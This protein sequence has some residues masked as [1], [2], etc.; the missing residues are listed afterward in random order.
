MFSKRKMVPVKT[1]EQSALSL[2]AWAAFLIV[3]SSALSCMFSVELVF[4]RMTIPVFEWAVIACYIAAWKWLTRERLSACA[5]K[6]VLL[7]FVL[8]ISFLG[9]DL[10]SQLWSDTPLRGAYLLYVSGFI[11]MVS[12]ILAWWGGRLMAHLIDTGGDPEDIRKDDLIFLPIFFMALYH[13]VFYCTSGHRSRCVMIC[14]MIAASFYL[15]RQK[16][17]IETIRRSLKPLSRVVTDRRFLMALVFCV[18]F[19]ARY[20]FLANLLRIEGAD[21]PLASDDGPTYDRWARIGAKDPMVFLRESPFYFKVFYS[22]LPALVYRV[23]GHSYCVLGVIQSLLGAL[24]A[25]GI[26]V[27]TSMILG[28]RSAA[29]IASCGIAMNSTLIHL[30]TTITTE[31]LYIPL[32]VFFITL[33]LYYRESAHDRKA[34][35]LLSLAGL[36]CGIAAVVRE[37]ALGIG[38]F[39]ALWILIWGRPYLRSGFMRRTRDAIILL[40]FMAIP[41]L[42][43]TSI[44]YRNTGEFYLV[45]KGQEIRDQSGEIVGWRKAGSYEWI[46]KSSVWG[47]D[48]VPSNQRLVELGIRDPFKDPLGSLAAAARSPQAVLRALASIV[49]KRMRNLFFWPNF[50]RFDPILLL[51]GSQYATRYASNL[52][53]Y[54]VILIVFSVFAFLFS[55]IPWAHKSLLLIV[56]VFYTLFHGILFLSMNARYRSPMDPFLSVITAFGIST[57]VHYYRRTAS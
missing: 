51:N 13:A 29:F 44:N 3:M 46:V 47:E 16:A 21:Y 9:I 55:G 41:V 40:F 56:I 15:A 31:A 5:I 4:R 28:K 24:V 19:L 11:V 10:E 57:L 20:L 54:I 23:F 14:A 52:E 42:F 34:K 7:G 8:S 30:S 1:I 45:Y 26:F 27:L 6:G 36:L 48:L 25:L 53:F 18:A 35:A 49:P 32:I 43:I 39:V 33:V 38:V 12:L 37:I 50:G 17:I 22:V 2:I